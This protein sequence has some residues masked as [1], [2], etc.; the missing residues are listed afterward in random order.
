MQTYTGKQYLQIDIANCYGL[1]KELFHNRIEWVDNHELQLEALVDKAENPFEYLAAVMAY[2]DAQSSIPTGHMVSFDACASGL[3]IMAALT[4]CPITAENTGLT[5][6]RRADIYSKCTGVM[7]G[8]LGSEVEVKR[9]E[10][11]KALMTRFYGSK[12]TPKRIF[13]EGTDEFNA[14]YKACEIVAP[15]AT[16]LLDVLLAAWQPYAL[17]H[18]WIMPDGFHVKVKVMTPVDTKVEVDE[19]DHASFMYRHEINL[20]TERGL[21]LAA[22]TVHSCDGMVVRELCRRC[23]YNLNTLIHTRNLLMNYIASTAPHDRTCVPLIEEYAMKSGFV[24][25]VGIDHVNHAS[26]VDFGH[27]YLLKLYSL[28]DH[29]L[30][31]KPFPVVTIHDAFKAHPNNINTV[32][33]TYIDIM[34]EIAESNMLEFMLSQIEDKP[35]TIQKYSPDLGELIRDGE[36]ALS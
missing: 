8:I 26:I 25:I 27:P 6:K 1:D 21:S 2:R 10:V 17:S 32:R 24:S 4:G 5:G 18:D 13:G 19:L 15:G 11:K 29:V 30:E 3:Q 22:N 16:E 31:H 20:G 7:G 12:D 9:P 14:F 34:A 36:Y 23:N 28:V 35:V 33:Q